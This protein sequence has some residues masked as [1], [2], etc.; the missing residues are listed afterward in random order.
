MKLNLTG[1]AFHGE[2]LVKKYSTTIGRDP[3]CDWSVS[4]EKLSRVHCEITID[5]ENKKIGVIDNNSK[6]GIRIDGERIEPN[7]KIYISPKSTILLANELILTIDLAHQKTTHEK[8]FSLT[9]SHEIPKGLE[10]QNLKK[11][12]TE[13]KKK[14][15]YLSALAGLIIAVLIYFLMK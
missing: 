7:R 10:K 8:L 15:I 3:S 2:F 13:K 1:P 6:N 11:K 4:H 9:S 5:I 12:P 14:I